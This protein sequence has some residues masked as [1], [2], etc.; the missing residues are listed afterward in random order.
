[1]RKLRI[2]EMVNY[3]GGEFKWRSFA[4]GLCDGFAIGVAITGNLLGGAAI[5]GGCQWFGIG[6]NI[7]DNLP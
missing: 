3:N 6:S 7:Y 2:N 1:M 4:S 5:A